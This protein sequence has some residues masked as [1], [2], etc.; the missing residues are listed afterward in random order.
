[1]VSNYLLVHRLLRLNLFQQRVDVFLL[2]EIILSVLLFKCDLL[3]TQTWYDSLKL[4]SLFVN[5]LVKF[6]C[7]LLCTCCLFIWH[8][9]CSQNV[10]LTCRKSYLDSSNSCSCAHALMLP[11]IPLLLLFSKHV[12]SFLCVGL[13]FLRCWVFGKVYMLL[14]TVGG[15]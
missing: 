12:V 5:L 4:H 10:R 9:N 3:V 6:V 14:D 8:V 11:K 2:F 1:M 13:Y 15:A 7:L